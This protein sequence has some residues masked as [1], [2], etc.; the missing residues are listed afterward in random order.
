MIEDF[1]DV[2]VSEDNYNHY[3]TFIMNFLIFRIDDSHSDPF[4]R[5]ALIILYHTI[6][7]KRITVRILKRIIPTIY[8]KV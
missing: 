6:A 3:L 7:S 4:I 5:R 2:F 1:P 8:N